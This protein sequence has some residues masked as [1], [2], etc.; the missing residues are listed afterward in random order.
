MKP[1]YIVAK[2]FTDPPK[3]APD[4]ATAKKHQVGD[5][6]SDFPQERLDEAVKRKYVTVQYDQ[7]AETPKGE[8]EAVSN[9]ATDAPDVQTSDSAPEPMTETPAKRGNRKK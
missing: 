6:V 3:Y 5:D 2:P 9:E 8:V 1:K 7:V 4:R